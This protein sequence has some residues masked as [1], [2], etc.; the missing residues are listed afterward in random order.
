MTGP[1]SGAAR[2]RSADR[3][4]QPHR[5]AVQALG[6]PFHRASWS[7]GPT[8][9]QQPRRADAQALDQSAISPLA[10]TSHINSAFSD[11]IDTRPSASSPP[12]PSQ[13]LITQSTPVRAVI[14]PFDI[15]QHARWDL[16]P[17]IPQAPQKSQTNANDG[18]AYCIRSK[19]PASTSIRGRTPTQLRRPQSPIK[20]YI[21]RA[22]AYP[23]KA[24]SPYIV[25]HGERR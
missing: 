22:S 17:R 21:D 11:L 9:F 13:R 19:N 14:V 23:P 12:E 6:R 3:D 16:F 20:S 4:I 7:Q 8:P 10:V 5:L 25:C 18:R 24:P 15:I 1:S 2:R